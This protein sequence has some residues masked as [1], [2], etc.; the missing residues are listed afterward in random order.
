MLDIVYLRTEGEPKF[1]ETRA[2]TRTESE[3]LLRKIMAS[4]MKM[5][6]RLGRLLEEED[7]RDIANIDPDYL[8]RPSQAASCT[9]RIAFGPRAGQKVLTLRTVPGRDEK[10]AAAP[11]AEA[12]G[13][14]LHSIRIPDVVMLPNPGNRKIESRLLWRIYGGSISR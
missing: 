12:H 14:S 2:P 6:T 13:F 11:C 7:V 8:R 5:L 1:L 4:L 3:G 10:A 9:Y